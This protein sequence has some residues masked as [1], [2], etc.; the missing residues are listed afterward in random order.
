MRRYV[1]SMP[2]ADKLLDLLSAVDSDEIE[3]TKAVG[4]RQ[5]LYSKVNGL[6]FIPLRLLI[7]LVPAH[8]YTCCW[9]E[10]R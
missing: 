9:G 7:L 6:S 3:P 2:E 8:G 4:A 1:E 10:S 5:P